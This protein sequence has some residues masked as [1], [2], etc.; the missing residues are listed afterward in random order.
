MEYRNLPHGGE[1]ISILG[2]GSSAL[3]PSGDKEIQATAALAVE[4]GINYFDLA[5]ADAAPF[6]A[7]GKALQ[8]VREKVYPLRGGLPN[9]AVRLD[10]GFGG[11]QAFH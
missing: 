11:N 4:N 5:S 8:S 6:T 3:G 9:R 2:L 7:Y 10:L 1:P